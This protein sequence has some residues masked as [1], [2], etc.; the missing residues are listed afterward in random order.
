MV[1]HVAQDYGCADVRSLSS[2]TTAQEFPMGYPNEPGILRG[3]AQ[4]CGRALV[5]R[6]TRGVGASTTPSPTSS[7]SS[8]RSK[9][10]TC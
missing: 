3:W 9:N 4:R 8:G 2:D 5:Q 7:R 6:K 1:L 10:T